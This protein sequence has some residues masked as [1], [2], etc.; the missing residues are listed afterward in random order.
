VSGREG[1]SW[2]LTWERRC[3]CGGLGFARCQ[4]RLNQLPPPPPQGGSYP[5]LAWAELFAL[6][7]LSDNV[8]HIPAVGLGYLTLLKTILVLGQVAGRAPRMQEG[9]DVPAARC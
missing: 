9:V 6:T 1:C 4:S 5:D 2:G 8:Y 7:T 3:L